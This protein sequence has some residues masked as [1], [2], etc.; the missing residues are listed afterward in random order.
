[1]PLPYLLTLDNY[2]PDAFAPV[3]RREVLEKLFEINLSNAWPE[4]PSPLIFTL[5]VVFTE[6]AGGRGGRGRAPASPPTARH[7]DELSRHRGL[8]ALQ[9]TPIFSTYLDSCS[10]AT[11]PIPYQLLLNIDFE[12]SNWFPIHKYENPALSIPSH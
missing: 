2:P 3:A 4:P 10:S 12:H 11:E 8:I 5:D 9:H 1:M 6:E 7:A